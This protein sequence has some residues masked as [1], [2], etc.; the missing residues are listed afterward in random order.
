MKYL[1]NLEKKILAV[2]VPDFRISWFK[3]GI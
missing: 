3:A 1:D 2:K